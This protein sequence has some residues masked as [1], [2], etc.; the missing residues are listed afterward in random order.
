MSA[1]A[2][3]RS[4]DIAAFVDGVARAIEDELSALEGEDDS[5]RRQE[6]SREAALATLQWLIDCGHLIASED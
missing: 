3:I 2:E 6:L 5:G 4:D 1:P